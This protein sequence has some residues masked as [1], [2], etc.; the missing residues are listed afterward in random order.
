MAQQ[1]TRGGRLAEFD[2]LLPIGRGGMAEV[3]AARESGFVDSGLFAIKVVHPV[4]AG[5]NEFVRMFLHEAEVVKSIRHPNVVD[6]YGVRQAQGFAFMV[7]EW[8][9]GDSLHALIA[10]AGK[11]RPIPP[12]LAVRII[13]DAASG[14]HAAHEA[15]LPDGSFA[16]VVHRDISPHNILIGADGCVKLVDFGVAR[17][18]GGLGA[19]EAVSGL[20]GKFGYMSPEQAL[21]LPTL[22]R[23][24]DVFS[25]GIVLYELT[26]GRRLFLGRDD[27]ETL[28]LVIAGDIPRPSCFVADYPE[29]L[30]FIVL[31]ALER[32]LPARYA[33]ADELRWDLESYLRDERVVVPSAGVG[34]LLQRVLGHKLTA[35]R[36]DLLR[37]LHGDEP[38]GDSSPW[39]P[40]GWG[41]NALEHERAGDDSQPLLLRVRRWASTLLGLPL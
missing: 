1:L 4:F 34:A 22:D 25:L 29:A 28:A 27:E 10:E 5:R 35:R 41:R 11:R 16:G 21:A 6:V 13:A 30:E 7:M 36:E 14:L 40:G 26:T 23:R 19:G 32:Q 31:K 18:K 24:S 9:D 33:S 39:G 20:G 17:A 37:A 15:L 3:W 2:L 12:D 8:I 38:L